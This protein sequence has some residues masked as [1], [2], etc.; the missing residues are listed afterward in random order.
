MPGWAACIY[1]CDIYISGSGP[2]F[3]VVNNTDQ[4]IYVDAIKTHSVGDGYIILGKKIQGANNWDVEEN[5]QV[6]GRTFARFLSEDSAFRDS[7]RPIKLIICETA[8]QDR[9]TQFSVAAAMRQ[10]FPNRI[11]YASSEEVSIG[12]TEWQTF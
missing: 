10:M 4:M 6:S 9:I 8:R 1:P 3:T 11:I 2:A 7:T 12:T 5:F